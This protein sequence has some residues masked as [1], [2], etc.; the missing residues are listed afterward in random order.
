M[1]NAFFIFVVGFLLGSTLG[2]GGI[3]TQVVQPA[4]EE[5]KALE[6]EHG[7]LEASLDKATS[8]LRSAA[9]VLRGEEPEDDM[10]NI[11]PPSLGDITGTS[12]TGTSS[13]REPGT[14]TT[15]ETVDS[16]ERRIEYADRFEQLAAELEEETVT[17]RSTR[18]TT[19]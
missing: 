12:G 2:I 16:P 7:I 3:Y 1:R 18:R 13:L 10:L 17:R 9:V 4:G 6:E 5:L 14:R 8:A 19:R 11:R 15:R